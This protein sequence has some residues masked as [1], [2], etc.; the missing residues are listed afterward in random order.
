MHDAAHEGLGVQ[1]DNEIP[2]GLLSVFGLVF[3]AGM[4]AVFLALQSLFTVLLDENMMAKQLGVQNQALLD[5]RARETEQLNNYKALDAAA[6][7]YQ[8]PIS[9]AMELVVKER[10]AAPAP[11]VPA[12]P[13]EGAAAAAPAEGAAPA[14]AGADAAPAPAATGNAEAGK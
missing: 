11:A 10:A 5:L 3:V 1:P 7:R 9:Q 12:V 8:V 2:V 6:G 14:A 13:A 4:V